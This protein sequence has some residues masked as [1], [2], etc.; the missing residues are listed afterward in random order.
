M[1]FMTSFRSKRI[2]FAGFAAFLVLLVVEFVSYI[3]MGATYG[4]W[5]DLAPFRDQRR[6]LIGAEPGAAPMGGPRPDWGETVAMHPFVGYVVD[7]V[8]SEWELSDFGYY[9]YDRPLYKRSENTVILG[10]FGGSFAHQFREVSIDSVIKGLAK[11]PPFQGKTFIYT[12]TA[13][14]GYKQ[15]QQLMTLNYLLALG[16]EFDIVVNIDGFNEVA[17]HQAENRARHVFPA[18]PRS[19][20]YY[21]LGLSDPVFV[22]KSAKIIR[23][24]KSKRNSARFFSSLPWRISATANLIWSVRDKRMQASLASTQAELEEYRASD[25]RYVA[26]GPEFDQTSDAHVFGE[27]ANIWQRS[28]L[29]MARLARANGIVYVHALQPNQYFEGSKPLS[30]EERSSAFDPRHPYRKG[31]VDGYPLLIEG[32]RRLRELGVNFLDWTNVYKNVEESLYVDTCCHVNERGNEL[33]VDDLVRA[34][35]EGYRDLAHD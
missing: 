24:R 3:G 25:E 19:W 34:I 28:S 2:L 23:I 29:Q 18:Y 15:P 16:G 9:E 33:L 6:L 5:F 4:H 31:V 8:R 27:I 12:S 17:L 35:L 30:E 7:P 13:L 14:G 20:Y 21:T 32:G 10:V 26:T 1:K 11:H 22:E